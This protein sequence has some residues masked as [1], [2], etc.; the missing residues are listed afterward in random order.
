[1]PKLCGDTSQWEWGELVEEL[2]FPEQ[3]RV[4]SKVTPSYLITIVKTYFSSPLT[5]STLS[6][7]GS[8]QSF[9]SAT[10]PG[11]TFCGTALE[12]LT[13]LMVLCGLGLLSTPLILERRLRTPLEV[14][15][16]SIRTVEPGLAGEVLRLDV[17]GFGVLDIRAN[18]YWSKTQ[19]SRGR[20]LVKSNELPFHLR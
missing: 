5:W 14:V 16:L 20:R 8:L 13:W 2:E 1:M 19:W 3:I 18:L 4:H 9:M 10:L 11:F 12:S 7:S 15:G 17:K 6:S